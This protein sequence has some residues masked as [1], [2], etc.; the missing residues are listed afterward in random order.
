MWRPTSVAVIFLAMGMVIAMSPAVRA[1]LSEQ[2]FIELL[3]PPPG[4][5]LPAD[6]EATLFVRLDAQTGGAIPLQFAAN[7]LAIHTVYVDS[8]S[9]GMIV[10][11]EAAPFEMIMQDKP[12]GIVIANLFSAAPVFA[13]GG[14]VVDLGIMAAP[15]TADLSGYW[16]L[17]DDI[18]PSATYAFDVVYVPVPEPGTIAMLLTGLVGSGLL[19]WRRRR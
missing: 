1:D 18:D 11:G 19:I 14:E 5:E 2:D 17:D 9:G 13:A 3:A 15:G 7:N 4:Y 12:E 16:M 8:P 6:G 10:G